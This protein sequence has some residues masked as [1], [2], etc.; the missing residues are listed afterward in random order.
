MAYPGFTAAC[1]IIGDEILNGKTRDSNAFFLAKYL[2]DLGID[3]KRVEV[4]G[5]DYDAI[6]ETVQRLSSAHDIVFTSGGIGPT[7]D[8]ITYDALARA[9]GLPLK[10]DEE[11][12]DLMKKSATSSHWTLT[13][14]R[15][16]MAIFPHPAE[17]L[18]ETTDFWVPVVVVNKNVHVLPGIP[19]LFEGLLASLRPHFE[20]L[21]EAKNGALTHYYRVQIATSLPEGEI[22]PY[23]TTVQ[24]RVKESHIKI[25]SYPKWGDDTDGVRVVVSIVGKDQDRVQ[26]IGKEI[27]QLVKGWT[28]ESPSPSSSSSLSSVSAHKPSS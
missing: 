16:R 4:I 15:K 27:A 18:R 6:A 21:V 10:L 9:Y 24:A 11:T 3:L 12:C 17:I 7:H 13:E 2:F 1:C 28:Y 20:S 19:K 26:S 23:L 5:D 8:D 22:A 14:E 25:G